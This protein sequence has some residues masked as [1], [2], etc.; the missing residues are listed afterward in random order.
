M[1]STSQLRRFRAEKTPLPE[2][3]E[4]SLSGESPPE[5]TAT[6]TVLDIMGIILPHA[7][8]VSKDA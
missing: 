4:T 8:G 5:S 6:L 2:R 1:S 3:K 7:Q